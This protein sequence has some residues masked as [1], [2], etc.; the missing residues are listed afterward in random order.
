MDQLGDKS[1]NYGGSIREAGG[2]FGSMAA[3]KENEYFR[4]LDEQKLEELKKKKSTTKIENEN[5][6][7]D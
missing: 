4:R 1:A 2:S 3:A 7:V 6:N 5:N